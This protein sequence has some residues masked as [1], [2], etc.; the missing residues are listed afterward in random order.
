MAFQSALKDTPFQV[1][2]GR[3]PPSIY[4]YEPGE[5]RVAAVAKSM[6][7]RD[8]LLVDAR[9]CLEQAQ[10]VYKRFYDKHHR[11][12]RNAVGDWVWLRLRHYAPASLHVVTK[13]KLRPRFYGPYSVTA[14]INNVACRL[15]LPPR[16]RLHDVFHIG[17]LKKFV[18]TP[19]TTPPALPPMHHGTTQ[20]IP[21]RAT[22]T[23]LARDVRQVLV[24][25]QGKPSAS[26]TWEDLESFINCYPSFQLEDDLLVEGGRDVMWGCHYERRP[27]ARDVAR[28]ARAASKEVL[29]VVSSN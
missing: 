10:T 27:E 15:E 9:A 11:Y 6:A 17:L 24:H 14:I 7:E 1:V 4:S 28:R 23:H 18:G 20:L 5:S 22:R 3:E 21:K 19:P 26:A 29:A 8:E 16:A 2:Y 12:V 25:W 13:G